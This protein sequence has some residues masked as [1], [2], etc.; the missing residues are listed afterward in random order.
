MDEQGERRKREDVVFGVVIA[1]IIGFLTNLLAMAYYDRFVTK[2]VTWAQMD[3]FQIYGIALLLVGLV[4]FLRFFIEDYQNRTQLSPSLVKRFG[5][6]FFYR[7]TPGRFLRMA[8][9]VYLLFVALGFGITLYV[10]VA[11]SIGYLLATGLVAVL[12][13]YVAYKRIY[14]PRD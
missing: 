1:A 3:H 8:V 12:V 6:F 14:R 11:Q 5:N 9:G 4:G 13:G 2:A 7:F 10:F